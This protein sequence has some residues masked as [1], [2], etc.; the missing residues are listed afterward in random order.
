MTWTAI[1]GIFSGLVWLVVRF[2]KRKDAAEPQ[3]DLD[4]ARAAAAKG[5]DQTLNEELDKA[6]D[7]KDWK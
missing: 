5:D 7:R 1:I 2:F 3:T 4:R 6:K